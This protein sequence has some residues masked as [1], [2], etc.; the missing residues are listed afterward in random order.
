M[1]K[2]YTT[3]TCAQCKTVKQYLDKKNHYYEEINITQQP[4]RAQEVQELSGTLSVPVTLVA[5]GNDKTVVR[6]WNPSQLIPA[7][8]KLDA[9]TLQ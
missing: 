5:H 6:G 2:V 4:E 8:M 9:H 7:L 1:I 3:D